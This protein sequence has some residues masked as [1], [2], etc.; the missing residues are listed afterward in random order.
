MVFEAYQFGA[1]AHSAIAAAQPKGQSPRVPQG[2]KEFPM[3]VLS[4]KWL[5]FL[6]HENAQIQQNHLYAILSLM[7]RPIPPL[8]RGL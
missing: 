5:R 1:F 4:G 7:R 3:T 8:L 6:Q 2:A